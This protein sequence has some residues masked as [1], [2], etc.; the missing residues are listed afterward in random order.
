MQVRRMIVLVVFL[1]LATACVLSLPACATVDP[2]SVQAQ[3]TAPV[4]AQVTVIDVPYDPSL[5][6]YVVAIEPFANGAQSS[7]ITSGAGA[8]TAPS[9][10]SSFYNFQAT[11]NHYRINSTGVSSGMTN[12]HLEGTPIASH[13]GPGDGIG[14]GIAAQYMTALTH[15]TNVSVVDWSG[16]TRNQDGTY[17]VKLRPGEV[18]PFIIRGTVTEFNETSDLSGSNR[19]VSGGV[20]GAVAS[21]LGAGEAGMVLSQANPTYKSQTQTR[22]GMV[23]LDLTITDGRTDRILRS[24]NCSGKFTTK[25]ATSGLSVFGAGGGDAQFAASALGQATRAA[26]NDAV[27]QTAEVLKTAR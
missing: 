2:G 13:A 1:A 14:Q 22:D 17:S 10:I 7:G 15:W 4:A 27:R 3:S 9:A 5:P 8:P 24:F 26:M 21:S 6:T 23:G 12:G 19:G 18:G 25:S 20:F 11:G 16:V